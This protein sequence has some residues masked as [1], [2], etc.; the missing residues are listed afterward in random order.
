MWFLNTRNPKAWCQHPVRV[1]P[2]HTVSEAVREERAEL[3]LMTN[4]FLIT[5]PPTVLMR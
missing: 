5:N 3:A 2:L 4:L 1:F